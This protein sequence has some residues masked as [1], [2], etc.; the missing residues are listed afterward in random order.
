MTAVA[1]RHGLAGV[2]QKKKK[3]SEKEEDDDGNI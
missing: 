1:V 3:H 2:G